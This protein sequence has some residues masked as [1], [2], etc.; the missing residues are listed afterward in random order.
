MERGGK[1]GREGEKG[2]KEKEARHVDIAINCLCEYYHL[3]QLN[4]SII[5]KLGELVHAPLLP[6]SDFSEV[7]TEDHSHHQ[8]DNQDDSN[9]H[10]RDD[11]DGEIHL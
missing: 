2:G 4:I 3:L 10:N 9:H 6:L 1:E 8:Q 11:N 5:L 7:G